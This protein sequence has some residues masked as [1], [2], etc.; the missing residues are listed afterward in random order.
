MFNPQPRYRGRQPKKGFVGDLFPGNKPA[1]SGL[2]VG[3]RP[4]P[5]MFQFPDKIG[6]S[7]GAVILAGAM[8]VIRGSIA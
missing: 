4:E 2:N 3:D 1:G 6:L 8:G 7:K 5:L